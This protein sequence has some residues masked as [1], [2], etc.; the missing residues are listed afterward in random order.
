MGPGLVW[1]ARHELRLAWRDAAAMVQGGRKRFPGFALFALVAGSCL[2]HLIAYAIE[3]PVIQG[4]QTLE[5]STLVIVTGSIVFSWAL[6]FSQAMEFVTRSFYARSDVELVLSSPVEPGRLFAVRIAAILITT[7]GASAWLVGPFI[8]IAAVIGGS[9]LLLGYGVLV[10]LAAL[11]TG[12]AVALV[13]LLFEVVGP[14]RTRFLSQVLAAVV[15]A[16][17][18]I[19]A[20]A[21]AVLSGGSLSRVQVL[22]SSELVAATPGP[23][24]VVWWPALAAIGDRRALV[25]LMTFAGLVFIA[26]T[27]LAS[28][29]FTHNFVMASASIGRPAP[30]RD[31]SRVFQPR[32]ALQAL[33][34][35]EWLLLRRD[36]WLFSQT[37]MQLLYLLPPALLLLRNFNSAGRV[38][39]LVPVVVMAAGQLAGGLAWIALS[40]ED[41]PDLIASAPL[42]TSAVLRAKSEAVLAVVAVPLAPFLIG[43]AWSSALAAVALAVG[44]GCAACGASFIQLLF[45]SQAK[46]SSIRRRQTSSKVAAFAEALS[47]ISIAGASGLAAS[48]SWT[49]VFPSVFAALTLLGARRIAGRG[50]ERRK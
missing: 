30:T 19:A 42:P 6:M 7:I 40:G 29:R 36:P 13:W 27:A 43:I 47:S 31:R 14:K 4:F 28:R 46:K 32:T 9:R 3:R 2:L 24:S 15:G 39:I 10:A 22:R 12:A 34:R 21:G 23:D 17:F 38:V 33:R 35:K 18:A 48:G 26:A 37:L 11:A 45:R 8:D 1:F 16:G 41:A 49:A 44:A 50:A 25:S 20:Q 5:K